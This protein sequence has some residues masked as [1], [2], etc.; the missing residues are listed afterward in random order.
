MSRDERMARILKIMHQLHYSVQCLRATE[1]AERCEVSRQTIYRDRRFIEDYLQVPIEIAQ[2]R[3]RIGP[4]YFLPQV[5][6]STHEATALFLATRL[7]YRHSDERNR[8]LE[9][10][11]DKLVAALPKTIAHHVQAT[12]TAMQQRP[13]ND[14]FN[15]ITR[16]LI[17][18]WAESKQVRI[19]YQSG[20]TGEVRVCQGTT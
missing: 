17:T 5:R 19:G 10:A 20:G 14:R 4:D 11:C 7:A 12:V 18:A 16:D 1:L 9:T 2:G 3:W 15:M 8:T 6:L 13:E